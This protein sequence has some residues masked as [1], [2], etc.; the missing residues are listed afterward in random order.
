[1]EREKIRI[2]KAGKLNRN[3]HAYGFTLLELLVVLIIISIFLGMTVPVFQINRFFSNPLHEARSFGEWIASLKIQAVRDNADIFLHIDTGT[4]RVWAA[5][6]AMDE[7]GEDG[8]GD[9]AVDL[10]ENLR[11]TGVELASDRRRQGLDSASARIIRMS[12]HG[13]SDA[14][15]LHLSAGDTQISLKIEPFSSRVSTIPETVSFDDCQHA[16]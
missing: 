13:Y 12:R 7:P 2:S 4:G 9:S 16:L 15:I 5:G 1:V 8:E 3:A 11:I 6:S 10:P 14:A